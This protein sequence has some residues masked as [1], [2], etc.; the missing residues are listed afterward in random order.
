MSCGR[1]P[2]GQSAAEFGVCPATVEEAL[3]GIHGGLNGGRACWFVAGTLCGGEIQGTFA[4]KLFS[5]MDCAFYRKV[6]EEQAN[7]PDGFV[8]AERL[9]FMMTG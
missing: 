1:Q 3:N 5:C 6:A 9:L 2:G 8:H 7:H 4:R